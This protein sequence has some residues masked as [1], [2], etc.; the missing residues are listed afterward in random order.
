MENYI[1]EYFQ[2]RYQQQVIN[3]ERPKVPGPVVT[4]SRECGCDGNVLARQLAQRLN[5]YY[6][7]IG[8]T[9]TWEVISRKILVASA[10]QLKT[11]HDNIKFV[12]DSEQRTLWE[13]FMQSMTEKEYHSE[14]KIKNTVKNVIRDFATKGYS[15]ILGRGGAQITRDIEKS[16]HIKLVA[17]LSW[18]AERFMEKHHLAKAAALSKIREVDNNREKLIKMLYFGCSHDLCYDV[19]YNVEKLTLEQLISDIV[20]LMQQKKLV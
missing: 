2:K 17:P 15:I 20:H 3:P 1:M 12:L 9:S 4:I 6:L 13:D 10:E 11:H 19:T 16:L 7:P 5:D 18:R 14:W 8:E